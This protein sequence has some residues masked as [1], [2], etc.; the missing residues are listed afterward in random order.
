MLISTPRMLCSVSP[1]YITLQLA[2]GQHGEWL[3]QRTSTRVSKRYEYPSSPCVIILSMHHLDIY[4]YIYYRHVGSSFS[5]VLL[6]DNVPLCAACYREYSDNWRW[7]LARGAEVQSPPIQDSY[8][9][10]YSCVELYVQMD[11]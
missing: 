10:R 1:Y 3:L 5:Q 7:W 4:I 6:Y 9:L 8:F 2:V 11:E